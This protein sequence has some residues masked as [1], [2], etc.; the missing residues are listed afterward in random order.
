VS[1]EICCAV[2]GQDRLCWVVLL[3]LLLLLLLLSFV[4]LAFLAVACPSTVVRR[5]HI[6]FA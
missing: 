2:T 1:F 5:L 6:S 3:L 4:V